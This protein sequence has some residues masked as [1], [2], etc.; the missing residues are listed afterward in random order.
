MKISAY[1]FLIL[2]GLSA[3][4]DGSALV[5]PACGQ[6]AA[7]GNPAGLGQPA[8]G[9]PEK[10]DL[11][12]A[13]RYALDHNYLILQAREVI[14]QQEGVIMQ[15]K[16][17]EIPN[18]G[19]TGEYQRNSAAISTYVPAQTSIWILELKATQQLYAGGGI[20]AA[21]RNARYV[22]DASAYD[23]QTNIDTALLDV[24]TRFYNV[25]FTREQVRVQEEN[26]QLLQ[27][28]LNDAQHQFHA[29]TISNFD[30]LRAQV[31][32]ANA[33]P[34]LITARN[35]YRIGIEQLR[36]S[37]GVPSGPAGGATHFPEVVGSLAYTPETFDLDTALGSAHANRPE[38]LRLGRLNDANE[39]SVKVARS[40]YY[41]NLAV[42]GG[43][44]FGGVGLANG[45]NY[46]ASGWLFGLQSSWAIFD[47]RATAGK[48]RQAKS[49]LNQ[50][51]LTYASE[52]LAIDVEVR[53]ALSSL[54]ESEE[55]V[56]AS[57]KTVEQADEALRLANARYHAGS[58][59]ELDVLTSQV[60]LTQAR[61]NVLQ[62]YYNYS[63]A[64]AAMHKALGMSDAA[65]AD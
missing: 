53:Q 64:L 54:Q 51:H 22:R 52:E 65:I 27:R 37:L 56:K 14:R 2:A 12:A 41:P 47:G 61:N 25:L 40:T 45:N 11:K 19:A 50:S 42:Y 6:P 38:L 32:L 36:Q 31:A 16:A 58:A 8:T 26:I 44:E 33:Q 1:R 49:V 7:A 9:L 15:V 46:D 23:L 17:Q 63:V 55:L 5:E 35:N 28:Q 10:L 24:R 48:V 30:V 57:K 62:A 3:V 60:A 13:I 21:V 43:Y 59:T 4:F 34:D 29:G 39:Q 18:L 20:D